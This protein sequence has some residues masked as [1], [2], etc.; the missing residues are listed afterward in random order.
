MSP[1]RKRVLITGAGG[2]MGSH[3]LIHFLHNTDW[4][5]VLWTVSGTVAKP[6]ALHSN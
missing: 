2:F 5:L 4:D 1:T 3:V 6:T